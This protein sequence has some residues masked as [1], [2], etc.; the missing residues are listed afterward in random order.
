[1]KLKISDYCLIVPDLDRAV[2]FYGKTI[3]LPMRLRNEDFADFDL[4]E[5][6]R[7]ALWHH[8]HVSQAVGTTEVGPHGNRTMGAVRLGTA[9]EVDAAYDELKA[10]GVDFVTEPRDW[11]W[12][13]RAA[14]FKDPDGYL[15]E[16]YTWTRAPRTL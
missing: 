1:M 8:P 4:G 15:W 14:Y 16:I 13:A 11:P 2:S 6:A 5:G 3:G 10:R 9:Q 12:G 7:L